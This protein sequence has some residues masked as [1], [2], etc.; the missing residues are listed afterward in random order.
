[1]EAKTFVSQVEWCHEQASKLMGLSDFG[2]DDDYQ[3]NLRHLLECADEVDNWTELGRQAL[4]HTIVS[5]LCSRLSVQ[6]GFKRNPECFNEPIEKPIIVTGVRSGTTALHRLL[7]AVPHT[8]TPQFWLTCYPRPRPPRDTW[9][10]N[11]YFKRA[12]QTV[13]QINQTIPDLKAIHVFEVDGADEN[14]RL[15]YDF[16]YMSF[17]QLVWDPIFLD[18]IYQKDHR[19]AYAKMKKVLQLIGHGN[20]DKW[21]MKCPLHMSLMEETLNLFPDATIVNTHRDPVEVMPSLCSL[22]YTLVRP[23]QTISKEKFGLQVLKYYGEE[24]L[25]RYADSRSRLDPKYF[26]DVDYR[27]IVSDPL[28]TVDKIYTQCDSS[29]TADSLAKVAEWN[30]KNPQNK[31]GKHSYTGEEFGLSRGLIREHTAKYC[32]FFSYRD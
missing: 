7:T 17:Q 9:E 27:D 21:V 3:D 5:Y 6:E 25:D 26:L 28:G 2:D 30:A 23:F 18:W 10:S 29:F 14:N 4:P 13:E 12:L 16:G 20:N 11:P 8:Q 19:K 1:M 22:M 32:D 15:F 31:H 24:G